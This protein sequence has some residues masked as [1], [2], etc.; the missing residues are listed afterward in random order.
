MKTGTYY[1]LTPPLPSAISSLPA[2]YEACSERP[3]DNRLRLDI[4]GSKVVGEVRHL[5]KNAV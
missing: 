5:L 3:L 1:S 2:T 4:L